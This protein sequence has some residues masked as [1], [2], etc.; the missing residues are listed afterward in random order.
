MEV[1]SFLDRY[2]QGER[3]FSH[4][5]LS[6]ANLSG[7]TLRDINL[8]GANLTDAN[9]SWSTFNS[10]T[11]VGACLR[12]ADLRSISLNR[13]NLDQALLNRAKLTKADLRMASLK[14]TDLTWAVLSEADLSG[15]VLQG[16]RLEQTN[17]ESCKLNG[18]QLTGCEMMEVNLYRGSLIG[19]DLTGANLREA[20]LQ[21]ANLRE[22]VMVGA[23]LTEANLTSAYMR[24]CDLS[25]ADLHRAILTGADLSDAILNG[26]DLSRANLTGTYLLKASLRRTLMLRAI[27]ENVYLLRADL[28]DANLR[29]ADLRG[30][31]L[32]G[33]Y[34]VDTNLNEANLTD[35]YLLETRV[36]RTKFDHAQMTG[37]CTYNWYVEDVDL[38]KVDCNYIFTRF[39]FATKSPTDRYPN[40]RHFSPGELGKTTTADSTT[41]EVRLETLN[42][43]PA[44]TMAV[45]QAQ[46]ECPDLTLVIKSYEAR[47]D[48][49]ILRIHASRLINSKIF[50]DRI[51]QLYA[52]IAARWVEHRQE[53]FKLME[54]RGEESSTTEQENPNLTKDDRKRIYQEVV[55]QIQRI[56][57]FQEPGKFVEGVQRLLVFLNEQGIS[58]VELQ[59]NILGK[60]L[61]T[62][63]SRDAVFQKQLIAW[64]KN[65][66][67]EERYSLVGESIRLAIATL[68]SESS[69]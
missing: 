5:D 69:S 40:D 62:R 61:V 50:A 47:E 59:K 16:A 53:I 26:A 39:D 20:N 29:G 15:A 43:W 56:I 44:L 67:S 8:T 33:A 19:S 54:I 13:V 3:D 17:L 58:T 1:E 28:S 24:S 57:M 27:L 7:V 42:H 66:S 45:L 22:A 38:S 41:I 34:L 6:G 32:S 37:C 25:D 68:L 11:L 63:S 9:L 31:D 10:A 30:A 12:Q 65:A 46:L 14:E 55:A 49:H 36:I 64:E 4:I 2:R 48:G 60:I 23:S 35:A 52:T 18:A 51:T 21:G